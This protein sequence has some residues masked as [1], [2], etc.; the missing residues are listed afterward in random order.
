MNRLEEFARCSRPCHDADLPTDR[1]LFFPS[2]SRHARECL[3]A[4]PLP[5][6][7]MTR[8]A[9]RRRATS[10]PASGAASSLPVFRAA[11]ASPRY[12][13]TIRANETATQDDVI[14]ESLLRGLL[15][16]GLACMHFGPTLLNGGLL[17]TVRLQCDGGTPVCATC[18]AVYQTECHYDAESESRRSKIGPSSTPALGTK[19]DASDAA[20]PAS[21]SSTSAETTIKSLL[22]LP[23]DHVFELFRLIRS[24]PQLD[25]V[26]LAESWRKAILLSPSTP[27]EHRS[28]QED[29]RVLLGNP[30]ASPS[31][32]GKYFAYS[33]RPVLLTEDDMLAGS[34]MRKRSLKSE[35]QGT[36]WTSVNCDLGFVQKLLHIYF[37]WSHPFFVL[38]SHEC[39]YTDFR[40]GKE[41]YCTPLLVNAI[42]AY[43]CHFIDD[44]LGRTDPSNYRTAGDHFFAEAKQL[45]FEDE[46]SR[47]TTAQALCVMSLREFSAGRESSGFSYIG[48]SIRMCVDLGLHLKQP[49]IPTLGMTPSEI[50]VRKVTFWGCFAVETYVLPECVFFIC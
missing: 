7:M 33:A 4:P 49:A 44:P 1:P 16:H 9:R 3:V 45:L 32:N 41:K 30:R 36:T 50:E 37:R 27:L 6:E 35:R 25:L 18:T 11:S 10:R 43:A 46:T 48:R 15:V 20:T 34:R 22:E 19:R 31:G 5:T 12:V 26:S 38:L 23:D 39:F 21:Q 17:L 40:A 29:F 28:L 42:C 47:L 2:A 8:P 13:F 14:M 24:D